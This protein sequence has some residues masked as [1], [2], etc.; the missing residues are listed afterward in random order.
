[1]TNTCYYLLLTFDV[2]NRSGY[3]W[4]AVTQG[5]HTAATPDASSIRSAV[6]MI[7]R[8]DFPPAI[9]ARSRTRAMQQASE[10]LLL[11]NPFGASGGDDA[12]RGKDI[13]IDYPRKHHHCLT[14]QYS[15]SS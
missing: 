1:M 8:G 12:E 9:A 4:W 13:I 6:K 7:G 11:F 14:V 3:Q 5:T 2:V 15:I 10:R